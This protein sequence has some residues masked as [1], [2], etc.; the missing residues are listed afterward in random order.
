[1]TTTKPTL[2]GEWFHTDSNCFILK[3]KVAGTHP[4]H[5]ATIY[6]DCRG[7]FNMDELGELDHKAAYE[8]YLI[9]LK[10]GDGVRHFAVFEKKTQEL[11]ILP[12]LTALC[13]D[14]VKTLIRTLILELME[15][16]EAEPL[17]KRWKLSD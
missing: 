15:R 5:E 4:V 3:M 9:E 12:E 11:L 2:S 1:M 6:E 17:E 14:W 10:F 16:V 13:D 7:Y 8:G